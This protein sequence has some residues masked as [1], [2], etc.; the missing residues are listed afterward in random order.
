MPLSGVNVLVVEDDEANRNLAADMLMALGARVIVAA[1]GHDALKRLAD[2][3]PDLI[4][5]D[6]R[7]PGMDGFA[8]ARE[9]RTS[10]PCRH[11]R[12]IALTAIRDPVAYVRTWT[13]GF[14]AHLEKPLTKDKLDDVV[15]R[16]MGGER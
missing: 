14:D 5:C 8:F 12:M 4:L 10:T 3:C 6:L 16:L 11:I 15:A 9:V 13:A 7:M 1:N 2:G